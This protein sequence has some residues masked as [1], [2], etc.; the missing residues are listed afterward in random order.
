MMTT[1]QIDKDIEIFFNC[2]K[3]IFHKLN[4]G[5][6]G[7]DKQFLLE[8][9]KDCLGKYKHQSA[10]NANQYKAPSQQFNEN[11]MSTW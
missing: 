3:P 1:E 4:A 10:I 9:Y 6:A 5:D 2:F 11:D 7:I 8:D